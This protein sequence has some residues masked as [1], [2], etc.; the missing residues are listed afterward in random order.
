MKQDFDLIL[1]EPDLPAQEFF[2]EIV[3]RCTCAA[4]GKTSKP[5]GFGKL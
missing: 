3:V 4:C 5:T 1:D 2:H